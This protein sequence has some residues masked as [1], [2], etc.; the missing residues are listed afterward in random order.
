MQQGGST[1]EQVM[2][3]IQMYAQ[4]SGDDPQA[5][6]QEL[7]GMS[8]EEQGQAIQQIQEAVQSAMSEQPQQQMQQPSMARGGSYS[9]TYNPGMNTYFN[10]GGSYYQ[11]PMAQDGYEIPER[12]DPR[13]YPDMASFKEADDEWMLNYGSDGISLPQLNQQ[14]MDV[15]YENPAANILAAGAPM[16]PIPVPTAI[17][18]TSAASTENPADYNYSIVNYL[19][20]KGL[21]SSYNTRKDIA[22]ILNIPNYRGGDTQNVQMLDALVRNPTLLQTIIGGGGSKGATGTAKAIKNLRKKAESVGAI[23][24]TGSRGRTGAPTFVAPPVL[25]DSNRRATPDSVAFS[26]PS[27]DSTGMFAMDS[28]AAPIPNN[29]GFVDTGRGVQDTAVNTGARIKPR[30]QPDEGLTTVA[31]VVKGIG[32]GLSLGAG[33]D[34]LYGSMTAPERIQKTIEALSKDPNFVQASDNL[35]NQMLEKATADIENSY[36]WYKSQPKEIRAMLDN[37][38]AS[39]IPGYYPGEDIG[40]PMARAEAMFAEQEAIQ[41]RQA[42]SALADQEAANAD[43]EARAETQAVRTNLLRNQGVPKKRAA[44]IAKNQQATQDALREAELEEQAYQRSRA[45]KK[46][47]SL[48]ERLLSGMKSGRA[49]MPQMPRVSMRPK[50][51]LPTSAR[52]MYRN[53]GEAGNFVKGLFREVGKKQY[54]G[55]MMPYVPEYGSTAYAPSFYGSY[56]E[57]GSYNNPGFRALPK[58]VQI[59]IKE[60]AP[61]AMYG[62]GMQ[63]GGIVEVN[64]SELPQVLQQLKQGGYQFEIMR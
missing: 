49:K 42:M 14:L 9:G 55:G 11:M 64:E 61:Q 30:Q 32:Y 39:E 20:K 24:A 25:A 6:I 35:K 51:E 34:V 2:Q 44:S 16:A 28:Q 60:Q 41:E 36:K 37:L 26:M 23:P 33:F 52:N 43:L 13:E 59:K 18:S 10:G 31:K 53:L 12:P 40:D 5:I 3:L 29:Y 19:N 7:Q 4:L 56:A 63:E 38:D 27:V 15:G 50:V 21:P 58:S 57:G 54:G 46:A 47:P 17:V 22:K 1:E 62:M 48:K 8:P 45:P